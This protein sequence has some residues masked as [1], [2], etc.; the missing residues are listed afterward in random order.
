MPNRI[1]LVFI[2]VKRVFFWRATKNGL[3]T[4]CSKQRR[5]SPFGLRIG[6]TRD[7]LVGMLRRFT[8]AHNA[9][10]G[11]KKGL[12]RWTIWT[13]GK[14]ISEAQITFKE[15]KEKEKKEHAQV[16]SST[17]KFFMVE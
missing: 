9:S 11:K 16:W 12:A 5:W 15:K 8:L 1:L 17:V 6:Q 4:S 3:K 2:I 13:N 10:Q 7:G 14:P